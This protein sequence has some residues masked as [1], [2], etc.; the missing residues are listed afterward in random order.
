[1][2]DRKKIIRA[3][4][5]L[6]KEID[7]LLTPTTPVPAPSIEEAYEKQVTDA[8]ARFT[9]PFSCTGNPAISI[10]CGFTSDGL[11]IGLQMIGQRFCE[12]IILK[13]A[14]NFELATEWHT[15]QLHLN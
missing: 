5:D 7:I 9:R 13:A 2:Q 14:Y 12:K 3:F 11:P 8:L 15:R 6:F 1:M 4:D 10:P